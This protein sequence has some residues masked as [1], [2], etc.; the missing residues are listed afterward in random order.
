MPS[1][2]AK[3]GPGRASVKSV[4]KNTVWSP[5]TDPGKATNKPGRKA[6][7]QFNDKPKYL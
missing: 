6:H 3:G 5:P 4:A 1:A 2:S 7:E